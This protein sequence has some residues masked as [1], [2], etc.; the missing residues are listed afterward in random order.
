M[1]RRRPQGLAC[2]Q[3]GP[4]W[5]IEWNWHLA[6]KT[7]IGLA[8]NKRISS[9]RGWCMLQIRSR[10]PCSAEQWNQWRGWRGR[11]SEPKDQRI[12][13][14]VELWW[15]L[16]KSC[17]LSKIYEHVWCA[18]VQHTCWVLD[19]APQL[20]DAPRCSSA[21]LAR[22]WPSIKAHLASS[23]VVG[24]SVRHDETWSG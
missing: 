18:H 15:T 19:P 21:S 22:T 14:L 8:S 17:D 2:G 5:G 10:P 23:P 6:D 24:S 20:P 12:W 7:F 16:V 3:L 1:L 4:T 9:W 13:N 11:S